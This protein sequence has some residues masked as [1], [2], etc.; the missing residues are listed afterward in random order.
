MIFIML[1][2]LV[3]GRDHLRMS[4]SGQSTLEDGKLKPPVKK[5][6]GRDRS[7]PPFKGHE[8]RWTLAYG[9]VT[10]RLERP[11]GAETVTAYTPERN[12]VKL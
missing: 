6:G 4:L 5:K 8:S 12:P 7:R 1:D 10:R 9:I 11:A 3:K 2:Q